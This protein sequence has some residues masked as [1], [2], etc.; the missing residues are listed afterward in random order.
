[1]HEEDGDVDGGVMC[2]GDEVAFNVSAVIGGRVDV[3]DR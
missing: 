3:D 2:P 1:L